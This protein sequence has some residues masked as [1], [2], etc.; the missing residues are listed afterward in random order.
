LCGAS[1]EGRLLTALPEGHSDSLPADATYFGGQAA[2]EDL[3]AFASPDNLGFDADGNLW[4][5]TDGVQPGGNNDGCFVCP[6]TGPE[7]GRVR[8]F[9]SGPIGAE[10]CGCE[11]APDG[12]T[13]FLT[14]Q[15]PGEAGTAEVPQ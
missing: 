5:V 10:V 1:S 12:E 7:R 8:Q 11:F 9:L 6:T 3:S 2:S 14:M 4:I 15:H 13:L